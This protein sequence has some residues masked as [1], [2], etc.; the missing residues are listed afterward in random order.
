MLRLVG[1]PNRSGISWVGSLR[2]WSVRISSEVLWKS[3]PH[4]VSRVMLLMSAF[5]AS[6]WVSST[7]HVD[8]DRGRH[9]N[10]AKAT[11]A[12]ASVGMCA[13][14]KRGCHSKAVARNAPCPP[15]TC[16][17]GYHGVCFVALGIWLRSAAGQG[18]SKRIGP[19]WF[20]G[21]SSDLP[22]GV[23]ERPGCI[24]VVMRRLLHTCCN[25]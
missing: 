19:N 1:R 11:F 24:P 14:S 3:V 9:R 21:R 18:S 12:A 4:S 5:Q 13:R 10:G 16:A 6:T 23:C 2:Q 20:G 22:Q 15:A 7:P 8:S 17:C 25:H